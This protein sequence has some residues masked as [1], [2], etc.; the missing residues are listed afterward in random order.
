MIPQQT[1][2]EYELVNLAE[3]LKSSKKITKFL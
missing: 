3:N 1:Y 2:K